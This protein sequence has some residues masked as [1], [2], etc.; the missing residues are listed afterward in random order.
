M[1]R[2]VP[3]DRERADRRAAT[4]ALLAAAL[5]IAQ[6]VGVKATRD[7]LFL[8]SF[9]AE[10]LPRVV[11]AS[12][13]LAMVTVLM[14]SRAFA[15]FGPARAVPL[16][17]AASAAMFVLEWVLAVAA[18][19]PTAV[20]LYLHTSVFGALVVSGF[21]SVV[22]ERFDPHS[23]KRAVSRIGLGATFGGVAGGVLAE[24]MGAWSEA[25]HMLIVLAAMNALAALGVREMGGHEAPR[26]ASADTTANALAVLRKQPYLRGLA[27][28]VV[29]TAM[30]A[31]L[32]D[33]AFK[34]EAAEHFDQ[35]SD[36]LLSFFAIFHTVAAVASLL[37]QLGLA[38]PSLSRLG[39]AG[40]VALLPAIVLLTA[41]S[42]VAL[43]RLLT[44]SIARG[45]ELVVA[46]S[47]FRSGY[48]LLYTPVT[49]DEKR[50]TKALIDV[51][52]NRIGDALA[53]GIVL[54]VLAVLPSQALLFVIALAAVIAAGSLFV[55]RRLHRGYVREL[56]DSLREGTPGAGNL[57]QLQA[58]T[59][60][61]LSTLGIDRETLFEQLAAQQTWSERTTTPSMDEKDALEIRSAPDDVS[62]DAPADDPIHHKARTMRTGE[63]SDI[64][65][66]L[67]YDELDV[68]LVPFA[69]AL[70]ARRDVYHEAIAALRRVADRAV[71]P[72]VKALVDP[73]QPFAIRR[74]LP[75]VLEVCES[76][77]AANGLA[78][79]LDDERFEVRYRCAL[80]L[81]R[82]SAR[83]PSRR[84]PLERV[85]E[86]VNKELEAGRKV[87]DSRRLL[88]DDSEE[89]AP[90][91]E[92]AV[93][94]RVHRSVEHV[95]TLLSLAYDAEPL[96][97]SLMALAGE[98]RALRGTALEYLENVLPES[99]RE[100][101]FP[102]LDVRVEIRKKRSRQEIV[103]ELVR[104]MQSI[105]ARALHDAIEKS[106]PE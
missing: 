82:I 26:A 3:E 47:V 105:D 36:E 5:M 57:S 31:G 27:W 19:K 32:I 17:F 48:E 56:E 100:Q 80:A 101:L 83:D 77:E 51:A 8:S 4:A 40:T 75:R 67:A 14:A 60:Q 64:R 35:G 58:A 59:L 102:M 15:R 93:R 87:W 49:T 92:R 1:L 45:A 106:R 34:A 43:F 37:M 96:R 104:S 54:I 66:L 10:D 84:P 89:E 50:P 90:L 99:T 18:P 20:I 41:S 30:S 55:T 2:A 12:A 7:A 33:Y 39:V 81:A 88:D 79:A 24:R 13:V 23:A 98:D 52:G 71:P 29:L 44:V 62:I 16:V 61:T 103:E 85:H 97:L 94:D 73:D 65:T 74:R 28:I 21:W 42:A 86:V 53:S 9:D 95:F 22:N 70:L 25:H 69:I 46:N 78:S 63:A 91:V 6:Q 76:K 11:I 38:K 72:L 68:R